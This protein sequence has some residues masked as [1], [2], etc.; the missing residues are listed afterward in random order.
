MKTVNVNSDFFKR[1]SMLNFNNIKHVFHSGNEETRPHIFYCDNA[2]ME[3]FD[4]D[5]NYTTIEYAQ[6]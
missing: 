1:I 6:E 3:Y 2:M 5:G 4:G